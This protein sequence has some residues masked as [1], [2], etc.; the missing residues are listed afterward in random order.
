M[1]EKQKILI[2]DDSVINRALLKEILGDKYQYEEAVNGSD[3]LSF[4]RHTPDIDLML[5]DMVM[6][7]MDGFAV[8]EAMNRYHWIEQIPVIVISAEQTDDFMERA[9]TLGATDYIRRPFYS[10]IVRRRVENTIMLYRRQRQL[11]ALISRQVLEKEKLSSMLLGIFGSVIESHNGENNQHIL[12]VRTITEALLRQLIKET[13]R[14]HLTESDIIRIGMA[15][16][17]HDIGKSR[18]PTELLTKPGRLT[19]EEFA[20]VKTHTTAGAAILQSLP[21]WQNDPLVK[22]AYEICRWHHERWDGS[23]YPDGLKGEAIPIAAQVVAM[24]DV[25]TA[26]TSERSYKPAFDHETAIQMILGNECGVFNPLLLKCLLAIGPQL[27]NRADL[28][29][30]SRDD[31]L[32]SL[33]LSEE[34]LRSNGLSGETM[35]QR[36]LDLQCRKAEFYAAQCGGIQFDFSI[37]SRRITITNWLEPPKCRNLTT[38]MAHANELHLLRP[39]DYQRLFELAKQ[40]TPDAPEFTMDAPITVGL[41][42]RMFR[43]TARVLWSSGVSPQPVCVVGQFTDLDS[44]R[45]QRGALI[46]N[47][48]DRA[49]TNLSR[50]EWLQGVFDLVR[51]V[52]PVHSVVLRLDDD[53]QLVETNTDCHSVWER[54]TRC[55]DCLSAKALA[56]NTRLCRLEFSDTDIYHVIAQ[57]IEINGR[58]CVLELVSRM[59][60]GRWIDSGSDRILLRGSQDDGADTDPLT[61]VHSRR[62]LEQNLTGA[63]AAD[64]VALLDVD[65]FKSI[66]DTYGH[67][68]GDTALRLIAQAAGSCIRSED[69][70]VRYG[71]DEFLILFHHIP[72]AAF[73]ERLKQIRQ[74][75]SDI[76]VP[77]YPELKL[78]VTVGGVHGVTPLEDAIRQADQR[79]YRGKAMR[80]RQ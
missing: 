55:K 71:G 74:A 21:A 73:Y 10:L 46:L 61:G 79:M 67:P 76:S 49:L 35:T 2:V 19:P 23:G 64:G 26:L 30:G 13:G 77:E 11:T 31:L 43:L 45:T 29:Q 12:R 65:L 75:V 44:Q 4:L 70:I 24:A 33:R 38:T 37:P 15:S 57:Y 69:I 41:S 6:P 22:T 36:A 60:D 28:S 72:E 52:D 25:Y 62:Y 39:E 20:V 17:L 53:G 16:A 56:Q 80:R 66:N 40:A 32:D 3:A 27:T 14:Y 68:V 5:L 7:D 58:P 34:L 50:L 18:V 59:D 9:Y 54:R 8:L 51:I 63:P 42:G 48:D 1:E 47:T 78:S